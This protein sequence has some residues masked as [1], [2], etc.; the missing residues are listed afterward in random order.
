MS[1]KHL[2]E[3]PTDIAIARLKVLLDSINSNYRTNKMV[4]ESDLSSLYSEAIDLF[5]ESLDNSLVGTV[6]QIYP[7]APSDPESYN[8]FTTAIQKDMEA[9]FSE[10]VALDKLVASS[11][12]SVLAE[13]D[14]VLF[15]NKS[16]NNKI[17]DYLL[18]SDSKLGGG[19]FFGDSF[20]IAERIDP[21]SSL[22]EGDEC[23]VDYDEGVVQLPLDGDPVIATIKSISINK[24]SN[25]TSGNN[26]EVDVGPHNEIDAIGDSEP[27]TWFEYEKVATVEISKPL[28]LDITIEIEQIVINH[29]NINPMNFGTRTPVFIRIIETSKDG[30]EYVSIKDEVPLKDFTSEQEEDIFSLA[31]STSKASGQG[32]YS[33]LPR[34]AKFIHLVFEQNTPYIIDTVNGERLRYAIGLRDVN[35]FGRKFKATGSLISTKFTAPEEIKKL[36]LWASENPTEESSMADI[37]HFVSHDDGATWLPVQPQDRDSF[38]IPEVV[39]YNNDDPSS[40]NTSDPVIT[41]RHKILMNRN[42]DS[43]TGN[44]VLKQERVRKSDLLPVPIGSNTKVSLTEKP[45]KQTVTAI[46]P[47]FGSFGCPRPRTTINESIMMDLDSVEFP[48]DVPGTDTIRF[49]LPYKNIPN[50]ENKL[51]VFVNGAQVAYSSKDASGL[52][53]H[54]KVYFLNRNGLEL[55]FGLLNGIEQKGFV[56]ASGSKVQVFLDGDNPY[57]TITDLGY[58]LNLTKPSDDNKDAFVLGSMKQFSSGEAKE[59]RIDIPSGSKS[60]LPEKNNIRMMSLDFKETSTA[61]SKINMFSKESLKIQPSKSK[62]SPKEMIFK[63]Q[64]TEESF[65]HALS[66]DKRNGLL[67]PIFLEGTDNFWIVEYALDGTLISGVGRQFTEKVDFIDGETELSGNENSYTF[68]HNTGTVYLGSEVYSNRRA[69]L[70]CKRLDIS[71][72]DRTMWDFY[73]DPVSGKLD[74]QKLL[75]NPK[76][77]LS[78]KY[79]K[80]YDGAAAN[81][82]QLFQNK[83]EHDWFNKQIVRGSVI[84]DPALFGVAKPLEVPFIDG[85]SEF[86]NKFDI[87]DEEMVFVE[88]S[89]VYSYVLKGITS[90]SVLLEPITFSV[91]REIYESSVGDIAFLNQ[92][93][94]EEELTVSGDWKIITESGVSTVY[95]KSDTVPSKHLVSYSF[96]SSDTGV[97]FDSLYSIDYANSVVCFAK[98]VETSGSIECDVSLYSAF[99]NIVERVVDSNID[100]VDEATNEV[101][102]KSSFAAGFLKQDTSTKSRP[103]MIKLLYEYFEKSTE[104]L[105][106]LEPYFSPIC[107]D[108]A[109]KAVTIG[110]LN[111]L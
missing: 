107:K 64:K 96:S 84:I 111:E 66:E 99:Y 31:S 63:P 16:V 105:K 77:V 70:V 82:I 108:V 54:S 51:R 89:S 103:Q 79:R 35:I 9:L 71:L 97:D 46:M 39:N 68:N 85:L 26:H 22:L 67:P 10:T 19:F 86:S 74:T 58:V 92:K 36:S 4:L 11:F 37:K 95:L 1:N 110:T 101:I 60:F 13:R 21:K 100:K 52:D 44:A 40:V 104:S 50:I 33:F 59:Y 29:I 18:Y 62:F 53:E 2:I 28:I 76:A 72:L 90:T 6:K 65:S 73:R 7:G 27:N 34:K 81:S 75:L 49:R 23:F 48:V 56:P 5:F 14:R 25:G 94:P 69:V 91:F 32:F 45:I 88:D 3:P 24:S 12:N 30:K 98:P 106:D 43:F 78:Q 83:K 109:F 42:K 80:D 17:G 47:F 57:L 38:T 87:T 61:P 102:F 93:Q 8:L 15:K 20:N 55:Q 41:L